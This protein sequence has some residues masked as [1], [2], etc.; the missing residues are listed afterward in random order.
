MF[1]STASLTD[2]FVFSQFAAVSCAESE[3]ESLDAF[4]PP[5]SPFSASLWA[6]FTTSSTA[7]L[8][9]PLSGGK[10]GSGAA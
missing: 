9:T 2:T 7:R 5:P 8:A 3:P 10:Q 6:P 4:L 1:S